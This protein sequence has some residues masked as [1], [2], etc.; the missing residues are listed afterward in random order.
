MIFLIN[1]LFEVD[2]EKNAILD[3]SNN[4]S[5]YLEPRLMAVLQILIDKNGQ[6][7]KREA[8]IRDVWNNYPGGDEGLN[9]AI[10][11]LRK[12]LYDDEK[13]LI[14]TI[15]KKG[16]TLVATIE[17]NEKITCITPKTTDWKTFKTL[18]ILLIAGVFIISYLIY[19][20]TQAVKNLPF[21]EIFIKN[22]ENKSRLDSIHQAKELRKYEKVK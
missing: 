15:P 7:V 13:K 11:H 2:V 8:L 4:K 1:E 12:Y 3:K 14:K 16:Y 19:Q 6:I 22:E 17:N 21:K 10:S 5:Q 18:L 9:Q 20:N